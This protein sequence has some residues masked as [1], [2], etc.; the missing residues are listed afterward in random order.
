M[1][2]ISRKKNDVPSV[3]FCKQFLCSASSIAEGG[4][5]PVATPV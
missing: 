3:E 2:K 5:F 4:I 1:S